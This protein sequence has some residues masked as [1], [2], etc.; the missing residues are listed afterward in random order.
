LLWF[1][2]ETMLEEWESRSAINRKREGQGHYWQS[3][4][5]MSINPAPGFRKAHNLT[6]SR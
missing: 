3:I 4:S 6:I 5:A 1:L 2:L